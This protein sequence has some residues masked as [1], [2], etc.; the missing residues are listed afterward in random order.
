[1][2]Q[3]GGV[4]GAGTVES[5]AFGAATDLAFHVAQKSGPIFIGQLQPV[6]RA[7]SYE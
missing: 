7:A 6:S 2:K 3:V 1:M 4:S 5:L